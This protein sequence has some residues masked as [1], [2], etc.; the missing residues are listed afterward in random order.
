M[1]SVLERLGM[2]QRGEMMQLLVYKAG[3]PLIL[4]GTFLS[5]SLV[6]ET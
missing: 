2:L 3:L 6:S 4:H 5:E 1:R